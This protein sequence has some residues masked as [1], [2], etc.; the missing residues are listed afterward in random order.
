MDVSSKT[1]YT[2][3]HMLLNQWY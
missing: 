1:I 3:G 2:C